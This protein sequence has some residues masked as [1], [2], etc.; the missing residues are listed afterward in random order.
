MTGAVVVARALAGLAL[1]RQA[2]EFDD[3]A[4]RVYQRVLEPVDPELVRRAC[5]ELAR[6]PV[7]DYKSRMPEVGLIA[8]TAAALA[9]AD[10]ATARARALA[11]MPVA[12]EDG[13][14]FFCLEC[15]D[16]GAG[17]RPFWCP[18]VG[19]G[20]LTDRPARL[21]GVRLVCGR[22]EAH[23]AHGY[24]DRCACWATN[25]VIARRRSRTA[26]RGAA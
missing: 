14:R 26:A 12:D 24:V 3:Q 16:E 9:R 4:Q 15:R 22:V 5:L 20:A 11:P 19:P 17:W 6:L 1:A 2:S 8:E 10:Q 13:P 7:Q 23:A 21:E 25:P 18:G